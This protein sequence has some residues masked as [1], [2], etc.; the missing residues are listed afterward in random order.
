MNASE[1]VKVRRLSILTSAI[2]GGKCWASRSGRF[3]ASE[4]GRAT[5][6]VWRLW[7]IRELSCPWRVLNPVTPRAESTELDAFL[8]QQFNLQPGYISTA[9]VAQSNIQSGYWG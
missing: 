8:H 4:A 7:A 9:T 3:T 6:P 5:E 1:G 2:D